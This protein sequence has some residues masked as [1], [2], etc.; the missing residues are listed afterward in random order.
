M[1]GTMPPIDASSELGRVSSISRLDDG[2]LLAIQQW[3]RTGAKEGKPTAGPGVPTSEWKLAEPTVTLHA[4]AGPVLAEGSP[5]RR[6]IVL[7]PKLEEKRAIEAFDLVPKTPTALRQAYLAVVP[8]DV[9]PAKVFAAGGM[10]AARLV[11]AWAPGYAAWRSEQGLKL[12]PG[13]RLAIWALY[14]PTGKPEDAA[15]DLNLVLGDVGN[16]MPKWTTLGRTEFEILPADEITTLSSETTFDEPVRVLAIIPECKLFAQQV[17]VTAR[18]PNGQEKR[19][20]QIAT[21]DRNWVGAYQP[22]EPIDLPGGTRVIAEISYENA[23]HAEGNREAR[24]TTSVKYGVD[25][26]SE[27]FWVHLQTVSR[28]P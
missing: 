15:F 24:P 26:A 14:Q 12:S 22:I 28:V 7:E 5:Y 3:V 18:F 4:K 1:V 2:E 13:D 25:D 11:G 23:G 27:L 17:R 6:L 9:E 20:L 8:S 16:V 21:W 19:I 10:D